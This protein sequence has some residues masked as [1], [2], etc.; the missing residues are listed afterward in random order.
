MMCCDSSMTGKKVNSDSIIIR[1][2]CASVS[3]A[4]TAAFFCEKT[5]GLFSKPPLTLE[6]VGYLS[7]NRAFDISRA[8]NLLG[9]KPQ[10]S[11]RKGIEKT[12]EWYEKK[13]LLGRNK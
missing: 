10:V 2:A 5:L 13:G 3:L 6:Q 11:I 8:K 9:Y 4:K 7:E 12:V 1:S